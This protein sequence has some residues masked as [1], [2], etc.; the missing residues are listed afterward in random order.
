LAMPI[1]TIVRNGRGSIGGIVALILGYDLRGGTI[2]L[3]PTGGG[4]ARI[5]CGGNPV[6]AEPT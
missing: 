3:T 4:G 1:S 5:T 2:K 6:G